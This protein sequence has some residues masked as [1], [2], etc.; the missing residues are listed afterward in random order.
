MLIAV[1]KEAVTQE[2]RIALVPSVVE[3]FKKLNVDIGFEAGL[4]AELYDDKAFVDKGARCYQERAELLQRA[5]VV[6]SVQALAISD[7]QQLKKG[8]IC[9]SHLDPFHDEATIAAFVHQAVSAISMQ[10]IPRLSRAQEMDALSSQSSLAGYVSVLL[11][12]ERSNKVLPMMMTAAGTLFPAKVLV[13]GVGVAGLQAIATAKRLGARVSA[14]DTRP[15]VEEQVLSLGGRFVKIDLGETEKT[16]EGYAKPL[17]SEQLELQ[18]K[19]LAKACSESDIVITTAL[20]FGRKA[21]VIITD[22]MLVDMKRGAIVVDMAIESGGNVEGAVLNEEVNL[23]GVRVLGFPNLSGYVAL[24]AS[25][26][27]ANNLFALIKVIWSKEEACLVLDQKD[28]II[29]GCLVV[30]Q[31]KLLT[32]SAQEKLK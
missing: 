31:G 21:P 4:G 29:Q 18:K 25:E 14:F 5:D 30:H 16:E 22:S 19:G 13:I 1:V 26:M 9:V 6:L 20:L 15:E 11:A 28:E 7:I 32:E 23:H 17:T 24:D 27:Y 2:S 10:M 12:A 3:K 8:A